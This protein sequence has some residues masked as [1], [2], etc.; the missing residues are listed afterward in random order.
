MKITRDMVTC[1]S[2]F[3][4]AGYYF[5]IITGVVMQ[6]VELYYLIDK[7]LGELL[8]RASK[9]LAGKPADGEIAEFYRRSAGV[10]QFLAQHVGHTGVQKVLNE[11][12]D[13]EYK[14]TRVF[15]SILS[16]TFLNAPCADPRLSRREALKG[17]KAA[18]DL[19]ATIFYLH[20][21]EAA[22]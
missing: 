12:P 4:S 18:H 17:I 1:I 20:Q 22:A 13:V 15:N 6:H 19:Y 14:G 8:A 9:I 10:K 11:V 21:A 3:I 2:F 5:W 16:L 7:Q